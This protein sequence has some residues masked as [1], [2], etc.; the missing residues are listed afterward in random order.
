MYG[1]SSIFVNNQCG[2][3]KVS[4]SSFVAAKNCFM[5]LTMT[6]RVMRGGL[7]LHFCLILQQHEMNHRIIPCFALNNTTWIEILV[8]IASNQLLTVGVKI[9]YLY[10]MFT[11]KTRHNDRQLR[12]LRLAVT[13]IRSI[14]LSLSA[15]LGNIQAMMINQH[16]KNKPF[17]KIYCLH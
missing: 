13:R 3:T 7:M 15:N 16:N 5:I 9:R 6:L 1:I 12:V 14:A 11:I 8:K 17:C 2:Y 4:L 10:L